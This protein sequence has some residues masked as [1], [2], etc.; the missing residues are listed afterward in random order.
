MLAVYIAKKALF[1]LYI[2]SKT[3]CFSFESRCVVWVVKHLK[4]LVHNVVV[5]IANFKPLLKSFFD[6]EKKF[7]YLCVAMCSLIMS[8]FLRGLY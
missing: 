6:N 1:A 8:S 4:K 5:V 3:E 2:T 7:K